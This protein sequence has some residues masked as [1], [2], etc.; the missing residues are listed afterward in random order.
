[1]LTFPRFTSRSC[2]I[3][4][5]CAL[6]QIP[7]SII[8][9]LRKTNRP[10][11][12]IS[13]TNYSFHKLMLSLIKYLI[14]NRYNPRSIYTP[15]VPRALLFL[16]PTNTFPRM[17]FQN[18]CLFQF[19]NIPL[20]EKWLKMFFQSRAKHYSM[21]YKTIL[22]TSKLNLFLTSNTRRNSSSYDTKLRQKRL[23]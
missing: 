11:Y 9:K 12:Q 4:R 6:G 2:F 3:Y 7:A 14:L 23:V 21:Q 5:S 1:M 22:F 20:Q 8:E 15:E 13:F 19:S 17:K 10:K 16:T 18:T